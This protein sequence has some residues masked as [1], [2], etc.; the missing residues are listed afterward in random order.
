MTEENV[1]SIINSIAETLFSAEMAVDRITY[2]LTWPIVGDSKIWS[3][4]ETLI[5]KLRNID[6]R[7]QILNMN[8]RNIET[9]LFIQECESVRN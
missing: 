7:V 6:S 8:V 1:Q 5:D 4:P 3:A 2:W 9:K